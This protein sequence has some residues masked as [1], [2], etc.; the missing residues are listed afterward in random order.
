[1]CYPGDF[2]QEMC[3]NLESPCPDGDITGLLDVALFVPGVTTWDNDK[4]APRHGKAPAT[5]VRTIP[6]QGGVNGCA[7]TTTKR[8]ALPEPA[9]ETAEAEA[10]WAMTEEEL[11]D[12]EAA[13][14]VAHHEK[15]DREM[16]KRAL[17][18]SLN[19]GRY[20]VLAVD[21]NVMVFES[22]MRTAQNVNCE[23]GEACNGTNFLNCM[24]WDTECQGNAAGTSGN[25]GS[26]PSDN[27]W[28]TL[29]SDTISGF[30]QIRGPKGYWSQNLTTCS[31]TRRTW[32]NA[33]WQGVGNQ[34]Q[35]NPVLTATNAALRVEEGL[36]FP[37]APIWPDPRG[38]P[39]VTV[40]TDCSYPVLTGPLTGH[41][42]RQHELKPECHCRVTPPQIFALWEIIS[43]RGAPSPG[44]D[45]LFKYTDPSQTS[46]SAQGVF[47]TVATEYLAVG[48]GQEGQGF[49]DDPTNWV[50]GYNYFCMVADPL[51]AFSFNW[52]AYAFP[53]S[54][55]QFQPEPNAFVTNFQCGAD[56]QPYAAPLN[57]PMAWQQGLNWCRGCG[58][59]NT[60]T[61]VVEDPC[62]H[63]GC[64][65]TPTLTPTSA[66]PSSQINS[67]TSSLCRVAW[68][69]TGSD[70]I[71]DLPLG[72]IFVIPFF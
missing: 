4:R 38:H 56:V 28:L 10:I 27:L 44:G 17:L 52:G 65:T 49:N 6:H 59:A 39:T 19:N 25:G 41:T 15:D 48:S 26:I 34:Q 51:Y 37:P 33:T 70:N 60:D 58:S 16:S 8:D 71:L 20:T 3:L 24:C 40:V 57:P 53:P 72:T 63:N 45:L 68:V 66:Y 1:M 12:Y 9:A 69:Y 47:R 32:I 50:P 7:A 11:I 35:C 55:R 13:Q 31:W 42:C 54:S 14:I 62:L 64:T 22:T 23:M 2:T 46:S 18:S 29:G 43:V 30:K 5:W 61:G 36:L 21:Y 67:D